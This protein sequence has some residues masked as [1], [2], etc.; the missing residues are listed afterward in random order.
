MENLNESHKIGFI[1]SWKIVSY[2]KKLSS[3]IQFEIYLDSFNI[4]RP[5]PHTI[6]MDKINNKAYFPYKVNNKHK[7]LDISKWRF[8]FND[9][10]DVSITYLFNIVDVF[11]E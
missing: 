4:S 8:W 5:N 6:I 7:S 3:Q 9:D 10:V 2:K 11:K 1:E